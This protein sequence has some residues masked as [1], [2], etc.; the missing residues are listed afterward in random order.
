M[1][2]R[3][4][5]RLSAFDYIKIIMGMLISSLFFLTSANANDCPSFG[6]SLE[7]NFPDY[8]N[9]SCISPHR[10]GMGGYS[11]ARF[12]T[13]SLSSPKTVI[14]TLDSVNVNTYLYLLSGT[15]Q[16]SFP[17]SEDNDG[18]DGTN[19]RINI[20][21]GAGI[22]TIEATTFLPYQFGSFNISLSE[23]IDTS[24]AIIMYIL[25]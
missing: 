16:S 20:A 19:S 12:Y 14:I 7:S 9:N 1:Y 8:W 24:P 15:Y 11:Y 4:I 13:F 21:L 3:K 25:D 10:E 17:I 23:D 5:K 6:L 2:E 22:Y 18:G